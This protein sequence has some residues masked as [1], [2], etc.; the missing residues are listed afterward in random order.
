[1]STGQ[2]MLE[3]DLDHAFALSKT[4]CVLCFGSNGC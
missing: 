1:M 4:Y 3:F 2:L